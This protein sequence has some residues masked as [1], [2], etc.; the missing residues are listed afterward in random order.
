LHSTG[1]K[2]G[3]SLSAISANGAAFDDT[4]LADL[5]ESEGYGYKYA[6]RPAAKVSP[7]ARQG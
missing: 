5:A 7:S 3:S 2:T 1:F 4:A 6:N